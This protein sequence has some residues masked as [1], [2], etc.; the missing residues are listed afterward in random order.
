MD[1][2]EIYLLTA[3]VCAACDGEIAPEEVALVKQLCD[4]S[5]LFGDLDV[6]AKLN[7][8]VSAIN[9]HGMRFINNFLRVLE[10]ADLTQDEQ[11]E[12]VKIAID[13]IEADG[14]I[15]YSEVKFF[16]KLRPCLNISDEAILAVLPDKEDY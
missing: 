14:Q 13:M 12:V 4:K 3:F 16:K 2:K 10:D 6:E 15:L 11:L 1:I 9:E 8:Y 7:E 5:S